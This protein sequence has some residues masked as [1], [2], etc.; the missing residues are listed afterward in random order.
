MPETTEESLLAAT[1]SS[2]YS[3]SFAENLCHWL[4]ARMAWD[5]VT[6]LAYFQNR[7]PVLLLTKGNEPEAYK[8]I[9]KIYLAGVY[10]LDPFHDLHV[11]TAPVGVYWLRDISPD[12]FQNT[13]YY[14]DYYKR[15]KMCDELAFITYPTPGVSVH[16]CL[17]R[18]ATSNKN[19]TPKTLAKARKAAPI[20]NA[21]A[22]RHWSGLKSEGA[23]DG[24]EMITRLI[25]TM[26]NYHK[27]R[28]S[29]R[30]AEVAILVLRGHSSV[31]IGL[32]LGISFQTVK[33]FRKQLYKKC[34]ISTQ[35]Q[36][37]TLMI[38]ILGTLS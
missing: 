19:F 2:L 38:P 29:P 35:A 11:N 12:K 36:L 27:V 31:S 26:M 6:I 34:N 23:Y 25:E 28:L 30:Q 7:V 8:N 3:D 15:T 1:I 18:D 22:Q 21:L 16:V 37:F 9:N 17:G 33:V 5:N 10:L 4:G 13:R 14:L 24:G 32:R 20:V